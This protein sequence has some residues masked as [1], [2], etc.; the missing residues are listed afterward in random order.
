MQIDFINTSILSLSFIEACLDASLLISNLEPFDC[1]LQ[2]SSLASID[3]SS[4][5]SNRCNY[6]T[7]SSS[8]CEMMVAHRLRLD[9]GVP[10]T[11]FVC[12]L[13]IMPRLFLCLHRASDINVSRS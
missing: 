5:F 8:L 12:P 6:R 10:C 4:C 7:L 11:L 2:R 3:V 13:N 9:W 1:G